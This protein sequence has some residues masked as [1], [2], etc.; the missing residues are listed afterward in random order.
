MFLNTTSL[1]LVMSKSVMLMLP[2]C[3]EKDPEMLFF[4]LTIVWICLVPEVLRD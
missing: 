3:N 1:K 4:F 2:K